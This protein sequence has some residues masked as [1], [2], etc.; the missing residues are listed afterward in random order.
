M[1]PLPPQSLAVLKV[2]AEEGRAMSA[3][4]IAARLG[5][6]PQHVYRAVAPLIKLGMIRSLHM[7]PHPKRYV[8]R[9]LKQAE[10]SYIEYS[11]RQ[12]DEWL[13][14]AL[15]EGR[16]NDMSRLIDSVKPRW[17]VGRTDNDAAKN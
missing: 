7:P 10:R 12:F 15:R 16:A 6:D 5:I 2:L 3:R 1:R 9:T 17:N 8:C 4:R 13:A 11:Q 14:P